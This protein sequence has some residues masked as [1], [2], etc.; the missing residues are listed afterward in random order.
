MSIVF[1]D[2]NSLLLSNPVM[3]SNTTF[4]D[5]DTLY[6]L[7][8]DILLWIFLFLLKSH[9]GLAAQI[10][11][12]L[13]LPNHHYGILFFFSTQE[14]C[15]LTYSLATTCRVWEVMTVL[16]SGCNKRNIWGITNQQNNLNTIFF[17][18]I[19]MYTDAHWHKKLVKA[20][21]IVGLYQM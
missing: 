21:D 8:A 7:S 5:V 14:D 20:Q 11:G 12:Y 17:F 9:F 13:R 18:N 19:S 1:Q 3:I 10:W 6:K 15:H 2:S 16:Y 4:S